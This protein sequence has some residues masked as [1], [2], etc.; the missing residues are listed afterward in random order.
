MFLL[1]NA[2]HEYKRYIEERRREMEIKRQERRE[3]MKKVK[4]TAYNELR[5]K[6]DEA[7]DE[8]RQQIEYRNTLNN[9]I[10]DDEKN[11]VKKAILYFV[12]CSYICHCFCK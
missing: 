7:N 6:L 1:K 3:T 10:R 2:A 9:Q 11:L 4:R 12:I 8:M 5:K